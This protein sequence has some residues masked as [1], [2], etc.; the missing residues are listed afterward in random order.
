MTVS[1]RGLLLIAG[2][3]SVAAFVPSSGY[4]APSIRGIGTD[5]KTELNLLENP[6]RNIRSTE[7]SDTL[8]ASFNPQA[9]DRYSARDWLHNV[10]TLPRSTVLHDI[11]SPVMTVAVWSTMVSVFRNCL[12]AKDT[13]IC[14]QVAQKMCIGTTPHS[15]LVSSLGL[16]LV[17][18]TNSAYQRF[19]EGRK[20]WERILSVSRNLTRMLHLYESEIGIEK[21]DEIIKMVATFPYLLRHHIKPRCLGESC[22]EG[23]EPHNRLLLR[24]Q[25]ESV[26]ET[27]HEGDK[28]F[29]SMKQNGNSATLRDCWVDKRSLP[30][31]LMPERSLKTCANAANRPL[32]IADRMGREIMSIP[33]N[34]NY[35]SRERLTLL[36]Q[37]EKLTNAIGECERIHQTAVPLN[38]ARHS[39]RSLSLWLLTLPFAIVKDL[40][41]LTGPTMGVIAWLL[42]GVYQIGYTIEDPFQGTLRLSI[43]CDAI[44]RDVMGDQGSRNS[45]FASERKFSTPQWETEEED[46]IIRAT[47]KVVNGVVFSA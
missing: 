42:F 7:R 43:L 38:Y 19:A 28:Q 15:F 35:T 45:A 29:R 22:V 3:A 8:C 36:G 47:S 39:L 2:C 18:R 21:K 1:V 32:W 17:F 5:S 23:V 41:I 26:L 20:I 33:Y 46:D 11:R 14:Q 40:G 30:W 44:R 12:L 27:R 16:L 6:F 34:P 31:S 4:N 37:V 24:E 10:F 25:I 9:D 13:H